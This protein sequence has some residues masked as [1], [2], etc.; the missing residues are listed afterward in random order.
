M[1]GSYCEKLRIVPDAQP[2]CAIPEDGP[3]FVDS[4]ESPASCSSQNEGYICSYG[5]FRTLDDACSRDGVS[6]PCNEAYLEYCEIPNDCVDEDMDGFYVLSFNCDAE[7]YDCDDTN[8][9]INPN[10]NTVE[11]CDEGTGDENC[12]DKT[13]CEEATCRTPGRDCSSQCDKDG[14]TYFSESCDGPDCKDDPDVWN[15]AA[16]VFPGQDVENTEALCSDGESNDCDSDIDCEDSDCIPF[17][18]LPTPTPTPEPTQ[19]CEPLNGSGYCPVGTYY[20]GSTGLCCSGDCPD[21]PPTYPCGVLESEQ[22]EGEVCPYYIE[23]PCGATP[24]VIDVLG[25]GFNLTSF[26]NGVNFNLYNNPDG[27]REWFSWTAANSDDAWLVFDRNQNGTID[28]GR[29]LFGN[30]TPQSRPPTGEQRNGFLALAEYDKTANGGNAD[31]LINRFDAIFTSLRLW[32]DTNHN[33]ISEP[34]ELHTLPSLG[35]MRIDLDYRESRRVDQY[36]NQFKYRA[37]VRDARGAQIGRWAWDV[38]LVT[39]P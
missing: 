15:N 38:I 37:K 1:S 3:T 18:P 29:E 20:D 33:G 36:G 30:F 16:D 35:L 11:N 2:C 10:P 23:R 25:N 26:A 13:N 9:D 8:P 5:Y 28:N 14:D 31:G 22:L 21:P 27:L 34:N 32:Q 4:Y 12:N 24:I 39:S 17:C 7:F 19:Y 6:Y